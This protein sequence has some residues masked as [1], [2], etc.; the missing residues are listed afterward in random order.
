[1]SIILKKLNSS[2]NLIYMA[3]ASAFL[4]Y[5]LTGIIMIAMGIYLL[6]AKRDR[7][8]I[9]SG[10]S[11]L[12]IFTV[13]T[14]LIG[15]LRDNLIGFVCS[16]G[17]FLIFIICYYVRSEVTGN[18]FQKGLDV[19]CWMCFPVCIS[20]VV[21]KLSNSHIEDYRCQ[22]WF[23]NPNYLCS[24]MAMMIIVCTYK[25]LI[26]PKG[27]PFY[28]L[29]IAAAGTAMYL[30]ESIFAIIEVGVGIFTL[31]IL[32]KKR[33]LLFTSLAVVAVA[34][35]MLYINPG[36]FPRILD[37]SNST[38]QRIFVWDQAIEYIKINPFFGHG[39][40]AYYHLQ[41]LHGS[42]WNTTHTHNF[43]FEPILCFGLVGSVIFVAFLWTYYEKISECKSL[44]RK[45][46]VANLILAL[47]AAIIIHCTVDLTI[48]WIQTGLFF[49]LII[50]GIGVDEKALN[51]R[52]KACLGQ[53]HT[54]ENTT[55]KEENNN[56]QQ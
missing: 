51:R 26:A 28:L 2:E 36:L 48:L 4:P 34:F 29:A 17:F 56:E 41:G 24:M 43:V 13:Y 27:K 10:K 35:I 50:G 31:L 39:F 15:L 8:F 20:T 45:N 33:S 23:F 30:G 55:P 44:L 46:K 32:Y 19:A 11:L 22:S 37:S 40:L 18:V 52:I 54:T 14:A 38:D 49:A 47:S 21:E 53:K 5:I 1:M 12:I 7:V 16:V 6:L 42:M 3:F 25:L 9:Y